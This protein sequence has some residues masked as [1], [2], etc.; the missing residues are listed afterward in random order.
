MYKSIV[1]RYHE[2]ATKG[3]NRSMFENK[4]ITNMRILCEYDG[5]AGLVFQRIRGRIFIRKLKT[6]FFLPGNW[7]R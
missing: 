1:C 2:I 5:I 7:K 4:L 6:A 3:H